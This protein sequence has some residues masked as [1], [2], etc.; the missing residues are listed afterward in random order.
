[1]KTIILVRRADGA[2]KKLRAKPTNPYPGVSQ[3]RYGMW[4]ARYKR[5]WLGRFTTAELALAA[6]EKTRRTEST[7][8]LMCS[9]HAL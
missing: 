8:D 7:L 2:V 1:M 4:R 9:A 3:A 6:I 5:R